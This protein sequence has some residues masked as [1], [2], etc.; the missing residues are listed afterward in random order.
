MRIAFVRGAGLNAWELQNVD[1]LPHDVVAFASLA[2]RRELEG[3]DVPVRRL[4]SLIDPFVKS[5]PLVR[6]AVHRFAGNVDHLLGLRRALRGFDVAHVADLSFAY[7]LQCVRARDAGACGRVVATVWEN[8]E[9]FPWENR[10]IERRVQRVAAGVDHCIAISERART[11]LEMNGVPADRI[12]VL[13]PGI[14]LERFRPAGDARDGD[15]P[16]EVLCVSRLV[17]EKGVEDLA[18]AAG[19]LRARGT[20]VRVRLVGEGP[21]AA[22]LPAIAERVGVADAVELAGAASYAELPAAYRAADVFVL[23]SGPRTTWRE[24]FGYAV[25]EAMASGLP[26]IAGHSGSLDEVVADAD[27]LVVPHEPEL[28]ADRLEALAAD[29]GERERQGR[30]N[31]E[32]AESRY[33]RR[34]VGERLSALYEEVVA[35]PARGTPPS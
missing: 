28:L 31:R 18:I 3:V 20:E 5:P 25:V 26:V 29:P 33:D 24:Q 34:A 1:A 8:I 23:A 12:T 32:W 2:A 13:P 35:R 27:S 21:L 9:F 14:D 11:H 22:K 7:S 10:L 6:A 16:L 15:G 19:L 4:P 17:P 30:R